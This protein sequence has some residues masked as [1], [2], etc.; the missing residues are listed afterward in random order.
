[1]IKFTRDI[2]LHVVENFDEELDEEISGF[3]ETFRMGEKSDADIWEKFNDIVSIQFGD[4][5]VAFGVPKDC[6]ETVSP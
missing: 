1:M 2:T 4:G 3:D 5:S 6:F